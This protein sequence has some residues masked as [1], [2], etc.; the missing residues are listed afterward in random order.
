MSGKSI[1]HLTQIKTF[2]NADEPQHDVSE[3]LEKNHNEFLKFGYSF[4]VTII[5]TVNEC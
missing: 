3:M 2:E 5:Y 4:R 1:T